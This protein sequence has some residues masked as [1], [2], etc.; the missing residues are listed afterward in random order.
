M[1]LT[2]VDWLI[3]AAYLGV[4]A[5]I[6]LLFARRGSRSGADYFVSGRALPWWLAGTSMVATTFA[7]D[8]PLAVAGM[9]A[10][11]GVAGN[12]LWW[13]MAIGNLVTVFWFSKLWRRSGVITDAEFTQ[14]RYSGRPARLLR[15]FRA[16]YMAGPINLI[17][18][19]WVNLAM[20]RILEGV[21]G[22]GTLTA[23]ALLGLLIL[24]YAAVA[25]LWG[26]V[27]T[28][29]F[30]FVLAMAGS[31]ALAVV[32]VEAVGGLA[33]LEE[34]LHAA[35]GTKDAALAFLP[36]GGATWMPL[37]ALL[38]FLTVQWW[39]TSYPGSEP[40]GGGYVAQRMFSSR[41]ERDAQ[42]ATLWFTVAHYAVRPWPWV[43]TGLAV[44]VLYGRE[45]AAG[46][47]VRAVMELLPSGWR[48]LMVAAFG[49]AYMSTLSTQLNWGASYLVNDLGGG[50]EGGR[51][52]VW[53]G[54]GATVLLFGLSLGVTWL[55]QRLGSVEAAWRLL[56]ALGA[57]TGPVLILRWY[58]WRL[59]AWSEIG[60]MAS[61]LLSFAVLTL[62]G[63]FD[64]GHPLEA[65]WLMLTTTAVT[66]VVWLVVTWLAPGTDPAVLDA[67]YVKV[68]PGGP[69][70]RQVRTR[71]GLAEEQ[72]AEGA[73]T[74]VHFVAGLAC[75]YGTLFGVGRLF[76]GPLW[77]AVG[78]LGVAAV[79]F[80]WLAK[81]LR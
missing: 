47:Y 69:G 43:L 66:T 19:G 80:G 13:N 9:V 29:T 49:A 72:V 17:V 10:E 39:A 35:Y 51:R 79:G 53:L 27:V 23:V 20:L 7:A 22:V 2:F 38:A 74:V 64:P 41:T 50:A 37:T 12:W 58:W 15:T 4:T 14:L 81:K 71:L 59:S 16:L 61:A 3:V 5:G 21:L 45:D 24:A 60:A 78:L 30:Q 73:V 11:H 31:V 54:R 52:R 32:A 6:G 46:G 44:V 63:V 76:F 28:D 70:W 1:A 33:A 68:R 34:G 75:V 77:Q 55:L 36:Q 42:L 26:V 56:I 8:T 18:I 65:V 57:G 40:G 62:G 48:G 67:F 25:G